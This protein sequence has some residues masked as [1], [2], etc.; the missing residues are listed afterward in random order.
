ML[1]LQKLSECP[2]AIKPVANWYFQEWD[3]YT[4]DSSLQTIIDKI[5]DTSNRTMFIASLNGELA[6]AG[7]IK[8]RNEDFYPGEHCWMDGVYVPQQFRGQGVSTALV[9]Y[10]KTLAAKQQQAALYLRCLP[11][12]VALY[13]KL[14]FCLVEDLQHSD[15]DIA[16]NKQKY[17]MR[18]QL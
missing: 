12:L 3:Q 9:E 2:D 16:P 13:Q 15:I 5:S 10:A 11:H 17:V 18:A 8:V 4:A 1:K 7:E 6:G 14:D